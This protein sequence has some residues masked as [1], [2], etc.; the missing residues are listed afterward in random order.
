M[1]APLAVGLGK[2]CEIAGMEM[3]RDKAYVQ[4]LTDRL[5]NS[6]RS[7]LEHIALNGD[8]ENRVP[9]NVNVSFA[10]VEGESLLMG[11]KV[12]PLETKRIRAALSE[13]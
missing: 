9:G 7:R 12:S 6:L 4:A 13:L 8:E 10:Y 3:E 1:P 5:L 2:A 11:L